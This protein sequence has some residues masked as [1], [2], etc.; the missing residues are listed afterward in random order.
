MA[1][2]DLLMLAER[3]NKL[4]PI[5]AR[6]EARNEAPTDDIV[7]V[8]RS[9]LPTI[10]SSIVFL[11]VMNTYTDETKTL[12]VFLIEFNGTSKQTN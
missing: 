9:K 2:V 5:S 12:P 6:E 10:G 11:H 8:A 3:C 1:L 4:E 7:A